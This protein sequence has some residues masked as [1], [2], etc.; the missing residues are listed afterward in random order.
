MDKKAKIISVVTA[1]VLFT[2]IG[3]VL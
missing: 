3:Y 1:V 2:T